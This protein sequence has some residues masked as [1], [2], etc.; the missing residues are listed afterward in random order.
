[1]LAELRTQTD[2]KAF[3][4]F[5]ST[6]ICCVQ[7]FGRVDFV[8]ETAQKVVFGT[9]LK[10]GGSAFDC[11]MVGTDTVAIGCT[12]GIIILTRKGGGFED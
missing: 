9:K 10:V 1:M 12:D 3:C 6:V 4:F 2:I 7:S 5:T 8:D 11:V